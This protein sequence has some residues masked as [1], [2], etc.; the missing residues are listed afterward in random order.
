MWN[1]VVSPQKFREFI[2]FKSGAEAVI[3]PNKGEVRITDSVVVKCDLIA[4][5]DTESDGSK[6]PTAP[7]SIK[8]HEKDIKEEIR[9][10]NI[11]LAN[12]HANGN[13]TTK[14][15]AK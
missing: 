11:T 8:Y 9:I 1:E 5:A 6:P 14:L 2:D 4:E 7:K 15:S 10:E 3:V 12:S 13:S